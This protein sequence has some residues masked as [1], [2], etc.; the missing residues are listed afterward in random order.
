MKI[1]EK[2]KCEGAACQYFYCIKNY[3]QRN[4]D[5]FLCSL[6]NEPCTTNCIFAA[7]IKN[8]L[9]PN[10]S[11]ADKIRRVKIPKK[12]DTQMRVV[13]PKK[14]QNKLRLKQRRWCRE[15]TGRPIR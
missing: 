11:C 1:P 4:G 12:T 5:E 13:L 15:L 10:L 6:T 8:K 7:C 14:L 3:L 2:K 9:L